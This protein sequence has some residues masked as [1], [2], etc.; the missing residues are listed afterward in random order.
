MAWSLAS[1]LEHPAYA[2]TLFVALML[3]LW[4][5]AARAFGDPLFVAPPSQVALAVPDLLRTPGMP[6][7]LWTTTWELLF[8]FAISLFFGFWAGLFLGRSGFA[9]RSLMPIVVMLYAMPQVTIIPIFMM[10]FGIGPASKVAYGVSHG[11]FPII[12]TVAAGMQNLKPVLLASSYSMGAK[13]W[14]VLRHVLIPHAVR[15]LFS[16]MRLGMNATLLG[17]ILA[18]LY[19]SKTGVGYFAQKFA[20]NFDPRMLFALITI[21]AALAIIVNEGLRRFE[22]NLNKWRDP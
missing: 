13:R 19:A 16:G 17:V 4:E 18:E 15:S 6:S 8:A 12:L 3:L 20:V 7:A 2:R 9:N 5:V 10:S 21:V 11:V 22:I 14:Q 1:L